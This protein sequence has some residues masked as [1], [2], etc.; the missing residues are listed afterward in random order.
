MALPWVRLDTGL[1]DHPKM[2]ALMGDRK[3]R[4]ALLYCFGLAYCGRHESDGFIPSA[5]LPL[6]QGSRSDAAAL[7]EVTLWH[8]VQGGYQV[9]DWD[10]YQPSSD[11]TRRRRESLKRASHKGGCRKNHGPDCNCYEVVPAAY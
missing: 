5:A 8:E 7:V 4:A 2:L 11:E 3:H 1:P 10:S 6:L 9:N